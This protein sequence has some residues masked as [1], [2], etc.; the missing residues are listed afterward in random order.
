M[1]VPDMRERFF[2]SSLLGGH[3]FLIKDKYS[4]AGPFDV[5]RDVSQDYMLWAFAYGADTPEN[6]T[7][8]ERQCV[9]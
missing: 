9:S 7:S 1:Q 8:F 4:R 2:N 6:R 3:L 5:L